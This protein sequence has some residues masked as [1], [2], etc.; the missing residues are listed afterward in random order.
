MAPSISP[1][2]R[3][4]RAA[5]AAAALAAAAATAI[6]PTGAPVLARAAAEEDWLAEFEAV[7]SQTQDAMSLSTDALRALVARCDKLKP[8]VEAL[9]PSR[10]KVYLR[11][12]QLCR[13]LFQFVVESRGPG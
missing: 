6:G 7:C 8:K 1:P 4:A 3:L 5:L 12:L 2:L 10:R 11:R 9:D 13:D